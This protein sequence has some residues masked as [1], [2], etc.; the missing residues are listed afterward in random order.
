MFDQ[1]SSIV[2]LLRDSNSSNF[3]DLKQK[4]NLRLQSFKYFIQCLTPE[5]NAIHFLSSITI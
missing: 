1:I 4:R 2:A 3:D 5:F